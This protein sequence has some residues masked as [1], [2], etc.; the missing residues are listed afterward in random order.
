MLLSDLFTKEQIVELLLV[1]PEHVVGTFHVDTR[2]AIKVTID[3][4]IV[5]ASAGWP[6][7]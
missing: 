7:W 6:C 1:G 5:S 2:G 4:S 3:R